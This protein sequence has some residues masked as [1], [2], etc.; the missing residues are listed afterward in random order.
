MATVKAFIK[1]H[2]KNEFYVKSVRGGYFAVIN[3][4]D[5]SVESLETSRENAENICRELNEMR[6]KRFNLN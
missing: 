2:S 5:M 3:G 4:Y 1:N 6:N